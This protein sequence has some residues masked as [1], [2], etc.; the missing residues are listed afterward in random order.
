MI[1]RGPVDVVVLAAG[2][3][4]FDGS[5]FAELERQASA[6]TIRVLDAMVL[7]KNE[8]SLCWRLDLEDLPRSRL[9]G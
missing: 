6:G 2:A 8:N 7:F 3:P 9:P 4:H 5:I 1:K